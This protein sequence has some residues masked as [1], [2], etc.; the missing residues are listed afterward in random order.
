M[1]I[2]V[3]LTT[4]VTLQQGESIVVSVRMAPDANNQKSICLLVCNDTQKTG[5]DFWSNSATTPYSWADLVGVFGY[6][7]NS[8][9][10]VTGGNGVI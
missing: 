7:N 3:N 2:P 1:T 10:R 9:I 6:T 8:T 5:V 4:P